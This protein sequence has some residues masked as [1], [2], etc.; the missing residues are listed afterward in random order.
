MAEP[1]AGSTNES[2]N[3]EPGFRIVVL[4]PACERKLLKKLAFMRYDYIHIICQNYYAKKQGK[5]AFQCPICKAIAF[6]GNVHHLL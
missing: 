6:S 1:E 3:Y 4:S 5:A 2:P